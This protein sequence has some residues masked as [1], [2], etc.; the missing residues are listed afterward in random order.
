LT[1]TTAGGY[2]PAVVHYREYTIPN[3][4]AGTRETLRRMACLMR[5]DAV[6]PLV[7][8]RASAIV[9]GIGREHPVLLCEAIRAWCARTVRFA[10]DPPDREL[11]HSPEAQ[12]RQ[13][14]AVGYIVGD[15]DDAAVLA[16]GL[17]LSIGCR[18]RLV[19]VAFLDNPDAYRHV[20]A[21]IAPP[22]GPDGEWIECD[23]T[24]QFQQVPVAFIARVLVYP[25]S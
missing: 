5:A 21:E 24:R 11:V 3:G 18:V 7:R 17:A 9:H 6:H 8:E 4:V 23:V 22:T 19:A 1:H 10:H 16:G 14:E 12:L 20:W 15:C 13:F 25:V 2:P